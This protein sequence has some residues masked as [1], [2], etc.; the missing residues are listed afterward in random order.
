M[1]VG[2]DVATAM[3]TA[4]AIG[5]TIHA[6]DRAGGMADTTGRSRTG[7]MHLLTVLVVLTV[8][9]QMA[10]RQLHHP[11]PTPLRPRPGQ[12]RVPG[13]HSISTRQ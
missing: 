7:D 3:R 12:H 1:G 4:A 13:V 8:N 6:V 10:L 9:V 2:I 5:L 11:Q